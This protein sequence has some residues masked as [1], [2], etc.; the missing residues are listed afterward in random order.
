MRTT[1][2]PKHRPGAA[3]LAESVA[4]GRDGPKVQRAGGGQTAG[5]DIENTERLHSFYRYAK[6]FHQARFHTQR[7]TAWIGM[8]NKSP[9]LT[10]A[11][12]SA[13]VGIGLDIDP[14]TGSLVRGMAD[15]VRGLNASEG[16]ITQATMAAERAELLVVSRRQGRGKDNVY[17]LSAPPLPVV[18]RWLDTQKTQDQRGD[19]VAPRS[20]KNVGP[21]AL[22]KGFD[23]QKTAD[24]YRVYNNHLNQDRDCYLEHGD[25]DRRSKRPVAQSDIGANQLPD[26]PT[27]LVE[28]RQSLDLLQLDDFDN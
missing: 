4:R 24:P 19:L 21:K 12:A 2:S 18:D 14:S 26:E 27:Y 13:L 1:A 28:A 25:S 23:P 5:S 10:L 17:K 22:A 7:L 3:S 9:A 20:P 16:L 8:A 15:L 6:V 11:Q